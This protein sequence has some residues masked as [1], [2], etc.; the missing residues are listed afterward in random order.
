MSPKLD[1]DISDA[2]FER[3]EVEAKKS[4]TPPPISESQLGDEE[5]ELPDFP[6]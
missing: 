3:M 4:Q 5:L 1:L 6:C 2:D